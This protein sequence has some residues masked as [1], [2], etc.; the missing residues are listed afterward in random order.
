MTKSSN[1]HYYVRDPA[2]GII[3]RTVGYT[4]LQ[5]LLVYP[6][7]IP[8]VSGTRGEN[9]L[10]YQGINY[11][12]GSVKYQASTYFS[13][14]ANVKLELNE[15]FNTF[16][17]TADKDNLELY[18]PTITLQTRMS[19]DNP[20]ATLLKEL[21][22]VLTKETKVELKVFGLDASML[23]HM[24]KEGS[25]IDLVVY[26]KE[27][28]QKVR[29][30]WDKLPTNNAKGFKKPLDERETV[31][32]RRRGYSPLMT[33]DEIIEWESRKLSGYFKNTKFSVM[34]VEPQAKYKNEYVSTGQFAAIRVKMKSDEI[35]CD[36]GVLDL[37]A[38]HVKIVY[39][40]QNIKINQFVTFLPSRMGIFLRAG[41]TL[42]ILGKIYAMKIS[43]SLVGY[44]LTQF[45]WDDR[46]YLGES[47]YVAK[48]EKV[49]LHNMIPA[50][51]G[52]E[53][54]NRYFTD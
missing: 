3:Y 33:E 1:I 42:F 53:F 22:D 35:I 34:P 28:A 45:P 24:D 38:H 20:R 52:I 19:E 25:D 2:T 12:S 49:D 7:Y 27:N 41:D 54:D 18:D 16:L 4:Y 26:G 11:P 29:E 17:Y 14:N 6:K 50:L 47:H 36:P 9:A 23:V 40:P 39:G 44:A 37:D 51:L 43:G 46:S 10:K 48:I 5:N 13:E 15:T 32:S 31:V 21:M 8:S 30:F